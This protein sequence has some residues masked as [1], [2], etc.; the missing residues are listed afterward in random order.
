MEHVGEPVSRIFHEGI[1][2]PGADIY[3]IP[4]LWTISGEDIAN[5]GNSIR[6]NASNIDNVP[7]VGASLAEG[8]GLSIGPRAENCHGKVAKPRKADDNWLETSNNKHRKLT[9]SSI[10]HHLHQT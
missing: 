2:L 4:D 8:S 5:L 7:I 6:N 1:M 3:E 10:V 9:Q